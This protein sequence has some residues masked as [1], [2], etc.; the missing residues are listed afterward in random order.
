MRKETDQC[1]QQPSTRIVSLQVFCF[2]SQDPLR[3]VTAMA[4]SS[5]HNQLAEAMQLAQRLSLR[6]EALH[7]EMCVTVEEWRS[8]QAK[9]LELCHNIQSSEKFIQPIDLD[10]TQ[11]D[12]PSEEEPVEAQCALHP[13]KAAD[14]GVVRGRW[15]YTLILLSSTARLSLASN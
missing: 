2:V 8:N 1:K 7:R 14:S 3:L 15:P 13:R 11:L 6:M 12:E 5:A 9:I 10:P 4:T